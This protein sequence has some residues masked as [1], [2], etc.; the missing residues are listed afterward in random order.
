[1]DVKNDSSRANEIVAGVR[2]LF[3]TTA[4]KGRWLKSIVLLGKC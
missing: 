4:V 2:A 3:K 1:M